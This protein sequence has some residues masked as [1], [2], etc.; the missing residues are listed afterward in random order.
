MGKKKTIISQCYV[1]W[2]SGRNKPWMDRA[3]RAAGIA[4]VL[5][6]TYAIL[7]RPS[8]AGAILTAYGFVFAGVI[9]T[10]G[11]RRDCPACKGNGTLT[12]I[13]LTE[14]ET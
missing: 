8:E 4:I 5:G 10:V 1:C 12:T 14:D 2:G 9:W 3:V 13:E 11:Y 7:A 6:I